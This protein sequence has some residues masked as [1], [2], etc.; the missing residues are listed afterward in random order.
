MVNKFCPRCGRSLADSESCDCNNKI[1]KIVIEPL[2]ISE[3]NR[4]F[5]KNEWHHFQ[6]IDH[7]LEEHIHKY[8]GK[9]APVSIEPFQFVPKPKERITIKAVIHETP[10]IPVSFRLSYRQ[11][12]FGQKN[13]TG[14]FEGILQLRNSTASVLAFLKKEMQSVERKGVFIT[15][16]V[17]TKDGVDLYFTD[18]NHMKLIGQHIAHRF[19]GTISLNAQLFS[20]NKQTSKDIYRLNVLVTLP[21]FSSGDVISFQYLKKGQQLVQVKRLGKIMQGVNLETGKIVG[22][23]MKYCKDI[24][25][26]KKVSTTIVATHPEILVLHPETFQASPL[27]NSSLRRLQTDEKIFVVSSKHGLFLVD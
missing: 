1:D 23:E 26:L 8:S 19:G 4:F 11:C 6:N 18:K 10:P 13:K 12:D 24:S 7:L 22:F 17:S 16:T 20:R 15:K 3:F 21:S 25:P 2:Q 5:E 14:Y 27:S 9:T